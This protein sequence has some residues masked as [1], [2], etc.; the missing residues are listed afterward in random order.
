MRSIFQIILFLF[1]AQVSAAQPADELLTRA[2]DV[3]SLSEDRASSGVSVSIR[4]VVTA[5][6]SDWGGRFFIQDSTGGIFV[7]NIGPQQ[8]LPG[9]V[10]QVSGVSHPGG[11]APIITLPQWE[12]VGTSPLPVAKAVP[13]E[14][15]IYGVEDSQRVEIVGTVR[16]SRVDPHA[17]AFHLVSGGY[18]FQAIVPLGIPDPQSL[19]GAKVRIRGTAAATF[20]S[21]LRQVITVNLFVPVIDDFLVEEMETRDPFDKDLVGIEE[22]AQYR[23]GTLAGGHVRVRGTVT[24]QRPGEDIFISGDTGGLH[25]RSPDPQL[26]EPGTVIEA[27]GFPEFENFQPILQDAV[28]RPT[29]DPPRF[30][31]PK[32]VTLQELREALH[33]S[34]LITVQA[35]VLGGSVRD[36]NN[37]AR[38]SSPKRVTLTLQ[39]PEFVFTAEGPSTESGLALSTLAPGSI[40][41]LTGICL[42]HIADDGRMESLHLLL[43]SA[44]SVRVIKAPSWLTPR[45]LMQGVALLFVILLVAFGWIATVSRKNVILKRLI[46]ENTKA[47]K[48]L[49]QSHDTLDERVRERTAQLK[50]EMNEREEAEVRFKATLAERTRLAQELHDTTEQSLT[51]IG[52]QLETATKLFRNG[53]D[54]AQRPLDLARLLVSRS[55]SEL[56]QSIWDLRSRELEQFDLPNAIRMSAEDIL[57]GSKIEMAFTII[58]QPHPMSEVVEENL[59]RVG[60]EACVNVIKH[61]NAGR[62]DVRLEFGAETVKLQVQD[63]GL[64]FHPADAPGLKEGHFGLLGISE[65][66]KRFKGTLMVHSAPGNGTCL[67]VTI[68]TQDKSE[69]HTAAGS[70]NEGKT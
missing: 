62:V 9:D 29:D 61:A 6:Q 35:M 20:N 46:R 22:L 64:G 32:V 26:F 25:I 4:G 24:Y 15:L 57:G 18:R 50:F 63:D 7:E 27:V 42:L 34:D 1:W 68:P 41:E 23:R 17:I 47:Q 36:V 5:A 54:G 66:A 44:D 60:R 52:L 16:T 2:I 56:R 67:E 43:P 49:Q 30:V 8:P 38:G 51:G 69:C 21:R 45:R 55:H 39:T 33:H 70:G 48:D 14:Q 58:G 59:L 37:P 65:R 12:R 53:A 10:V 19:V 11:F 3:L 40:L 31:I 13:I 28:F